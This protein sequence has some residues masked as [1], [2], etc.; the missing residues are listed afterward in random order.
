MEGNEIRSRGSRYHKWLDV[1][2]IL[3]WSTR[4]EQDPSSAHSTTDYFEADQASQPNRGTGVTP[5]T[6]RGRDG[7]M[8][9]LQL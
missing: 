8:M 5:A 6:S 1:G 9:L 4:W 7:S 3:D 2:Q